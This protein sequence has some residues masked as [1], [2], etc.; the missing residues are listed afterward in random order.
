MPAND[1]KFDR[2]AKSY[3]ELHNESIAAS[4]EPLEYFS[5]YKRRC[6]ERLGAPRDEPLLDYGCGVGN[7]MA[8][9]AEAFPRIHGFDPSP[10]SLRVAGERVP[11]ATLHQSVETVPEGVF[12]TSVL[13]GVLHHVPRP[14]RV[15]LLK[16][17]RTK[18][19]PGGRVFVFE[20]NPLNPVT[21]RAVAMCPFDDDADLLWPWLARKL[22]VQA[23]FEAVKLRFIVFFPKLL[24]FLR[25][26]EPGLGW[27]PAGAQVMVVGAR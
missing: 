7:V 3:D 15:G 10:E 21:R 12:A 1:A 24:G 17:V 11:G 27:L 26:L 13:S 5:H 22:L 19:R 6:L 23:G 2:Y 9:L 16:T 20:H 18:L 25:P 8:A 4:G 14:E